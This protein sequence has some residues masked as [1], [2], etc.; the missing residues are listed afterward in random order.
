[1]FKV[2]IVAF[3]FCLTSTIANA[4]TF[5]INRAIVCDKIEEVAK[6]IKKYGEKPIWQGKNIQG[7]QT[8]LTLNGQTKTWS[9]IL[10]DGEIACILDA[11]LDFSIEKS[12]STPK[13]DKKNLTEVTNKYM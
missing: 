13:V 2:K 1:M 3:L 11:G 5:Q 12:T 10:T 4:E 6:L 8:V 9:L 7:L